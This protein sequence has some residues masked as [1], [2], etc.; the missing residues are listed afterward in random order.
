MMAE[1]AIR[2]PLSL[3]EHGTAP[4]DARLLRLEV[5]QLRAYDRNPRRCKNNEYERIKASIRTQ[6]LDQPLVVTCRPGE[7][8]YM[9]MS[10]GNTRLQAIMDLYEETGDGS[11]RYLDCHYKPWVAESD[12][13][14][15]HL[16]E[17]ELR[18]G[19]YFIDKA[20]AVFEA[21]ALL[22]VEMPGPPLSQRRLSELLATLGLS[23]SQSLISRMAYAVQ[24]LWPL[25]P[26]ALSAGMG[27]PQVG[28]IQGLE[29]AARTLWCNKSL[30][31]EEEFDESPDWDTDVLQEALET[32]IAEASEV[33]LSTIRLELDAKPKGKSS[34]VN[35]TEFLT[36]ASRHVMP[37]ET[38]ASSSGTERIDVSNHLNSTCDLKQVR[39]PETTAF[40]DGNCPEVEGQSEL[41]RLRER[42]YQLANQLAHAHGLGNLIKRSSDQGLGFVV[43]DVPDKSLT[44]VLD[45]DL[46]RL[47]TAVWW[48]LVAC[49]DVMAGPSAQVVAQLKEGS[50]FQ[51]AIAEQNPNQFLV[52]IPLLEPVFVGSHLWR[53][54]TDE[55]WQILVALIETY[56]VL[57]RISRESGQPLWLA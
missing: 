47:V 14:L 17:N 37:E 20:Q 18:D 13:L 1:P 28:R 3:R 2:E 55:D 54:L 56:R 27:S 46:A 35:A 4:D 5:T 10:G 44:D 57:H 26:Q 31:G 11:F 50:T 39:V 41:G 53:W 21:K 8:D 42:A 29:R 25:I 45:E 9:L 34:L 16:R 6:G 40:E 32:E 38:T 12:V 49:S 43:Q 23:F 51:T 15:S 48:Q 52:A 30:G 36:D 24:T 7:T 33:D 19:L 22:E